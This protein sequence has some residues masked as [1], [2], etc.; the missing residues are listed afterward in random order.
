MYFF[1]AFTYYNLARTEHEQLDLRDGA[2]FI[3]LIPTVRNKGK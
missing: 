3:E 1:T 2:I